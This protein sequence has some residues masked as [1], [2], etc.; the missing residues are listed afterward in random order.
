M[1]KSLEKFATKRNIIIG[2]I[3]IAFINIIAFP[4]FPKLMIGREIPIDGILDL[5]FGFTSNF[6]LNLLDNLK[7]DGRNAYKLSTTIIDIPYAL[8]YGFIYSFILVVLLKKNNFWNYRILI[9]VP[10]G[11]SIFDL[12]ENAGILTLLS[13]FP[14]KMEFVV[15][16]TSFS[17]QSKWIFAFV[18]FLLISS[19]VVYLVFKK[20]QKAL[21]H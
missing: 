18:T 13:S 3:F 1:I 2:L 5:Q 17:N 9:L 19:N 15:A 11:I 20:K 16:F 7:E 4:F 6:A 12:M 10:F 21:F 8:V 14:E